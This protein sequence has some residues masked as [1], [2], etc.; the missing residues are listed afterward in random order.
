MGQDT[1]T[2]AAIR[3]AEVLIPVKFT[4]EAV[5]NFESSEKQFATLLYSLI[6]IK[7]F[8]VIVTRL[9]DPTKQRATP[10]LHLA[11]QCNCVEHVGS[12]DPPKKGFP[13]IEQDELILA[14]ITGLRRQGGGG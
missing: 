5:A 2:W 12:L 4:R 10:D 8:E 1:V 11:L 6:R 14:W 7:N 9:P 13:W 3:D